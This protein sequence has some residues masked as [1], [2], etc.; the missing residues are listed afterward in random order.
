MVA[1]A[2]PLVCM[3]TRKDGSPCQATPTRSG[4]CLAHDPGLAEKRATA[5][6][7]GGYNKAHNRRL[8]KLMPPRL[9]S[10]DEALEKAL[11]EVHDGELD[12]RRATAMASLAGALVRVLTAGELE[13]RVRTLEERRN[14]HGA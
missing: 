13:E 10:V 14:G 7:Q 6:K 9:V 8:A 11:K 2:S 12:S 1:N 5:R 3:A 4:F